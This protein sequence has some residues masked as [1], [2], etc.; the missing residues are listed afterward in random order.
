MKSTA[1]PY[2]V[3]P[4]MRAALREKA[5]AQGRLRFDTF[6]ETALYHP[7]HGYYRRNA[8]R[9]GRDDQ[10]DF[11]TSESLGPV[12]GRLIADAATA[13]LPSNQTPEQTTFLEIGAE[14]GRHVLDE[15]DHR[16]AATATVPVGTPLEIPGRA[17][18][19]SNELFD[20]QPFRRFIR[21]A[22]GWHETGVAI[23]DEGLVECL[24]D[25][26]APP[27]P[28]LPD[29]TPIGY[30]IDLPT[31]ARAL[32]EAIASRPWTGLFLAVDY[33]KT[34][35]ALFNDHPEGT[36]RAYHRHR[37]VPDLLARAGEQDLTCHIC[38]D[39]LEDV[40]RQRSFEDIR[41]ERQEAFFI[42][43]AQ[44]AVEAA[45]SGDPNAVGT[46]RRQL[47]ELIHPQYF[48][49]RFQVLSAIRT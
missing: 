36:A 11:Y 44:A 4:V 28:S 13:I 37:Q 48:G 29:H 12:F 5:D 45:L 34:R 31:G 47:M 40:L 18:V 9:V 27:H 24:L 49:T 2:S 22:S 23:G 30:R 20:A 10:T 15:I 35:H 26:S 8:P 32:A 41:L 17:V 39:D 42:K 25:S 33:G 14:E 21:L 16:F 38:W 46:A 3:S 19:F 1:P 43:N 6:V 7:L